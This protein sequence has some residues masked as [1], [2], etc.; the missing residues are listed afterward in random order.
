[1]DS[2]IEEVKSKTDIVSLI[3]EY[4]PLK[5]A[6]RNYKANCPFHSEK[7]P[8]FMVSQERGIYKCFGCGEGGDIYNFLMKLEGIEFGEALKQLAKRAGVALKEYHPSPIEEQKERVFLINKTTAQLYSRVLLEHPSGAKALG[9]LKERG[10]TLNSIKKFQL[11][12]APD[13][14]EFV[15]KY[16]T[17]KGFSLQDLLATGLIVSSGRGEG[18][19]DRFRGRIIFP[20]HDVRGEVV[21]FSGRVLGSEEP[22]REPESDLAGGLAHRSLG[23]GGPKYLNSPETIVFDKGRTLY[24][25][26]FAK[27]EIKKVNQ[28]V[29]VEGNLDV[30]SSCQAG[31][32]NVAAPL[33]TALTFPQLQLLNRY[34]SNIGLCFDLDSAGYAAS[35]R[36]IEMAENT[37]LNISIIQPKVGKD[38]D[39]CARKS[40]KIWQESVRESIPIYDY[41]LSSAVSRHGLETLEGKRKISAEVLPLLKKLDDEI[42]RSHYLQRLASLLGVEESALVKVLGK[43]AETSKSASSINTYPSKPPVRLDRGEVLERYLLSL[44]L[45]TK[46]RS[47]ELMATDFLNEKLRVLYERHQ[48]F[49]QDKEGFKVKKYVLDLPGELVSLVDELLLTEIEDYLLEDEERLEKE[50]RACVNEL[51]SLNLRRRLKKL[52]LEVKQAEILNDMVKL[53]LLRKEFRDLTLQLKK[54]N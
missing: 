50:F 18:F 32:K 41:Y 47:Q 28:V 22:T 29:L 9:Y 44:L 1:M 54:Y 26:Y 4:I 39:E 52:A 40:P 36:A 31:V 23:E 33:G 34:T 46:I 5:K 13:Q 6:G 10:L 43:R 15:A 7:T 27:E 48:L 11:G 37:G 8:S 45:Q 35:K 20:V 17:K 3:S 2:Q 14:W 12:Y 49:C 42:A 19:Y 38:P 30:I 25:L 51:K 24:G 16:L 21:G 53:E